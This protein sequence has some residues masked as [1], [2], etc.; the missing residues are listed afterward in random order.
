[1][2]APTEIEIENKTVKLNYNGFSYNISW[3]PPSCDVDN[4][5]LYFTTRAKSDC[6]NI[7]IHRDA[8]DYYYEPIGLKEIQI[9]AHLNDKTNCSQGMLSCN[10]HLILYT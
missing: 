9:A 3:D 1:M 6:Q 10:N 7:T 2:T 5:T 8:T 4:Y